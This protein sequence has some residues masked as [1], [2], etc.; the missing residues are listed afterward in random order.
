[1]RGVDFRQAIHYFEPEC[2]HIL[3][4]SCILREK[5]NTG[6]AELTVKSDNECIVFHNLD[7]HSSR[8]YKIKKCAD[9]VILENN[10]GE[11]ILHIFELKKTIKKNEWNTMKE[12]F[13]GALFNMMSYATI[14]GIS[15]DIKKTRVYSA[16][17]ED[18]LND[19]TNPSKKHYRKP[20]NDSQKIK[21]SMEIKQAR[22][23]W[24]SG[25]VILEYLGDYHVPN[26]KIKLRNENDIGV[27]EWDL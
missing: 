20:V 12:Q 13:Q 22:K 6:K 17:R 24:N 9:Q 23:E 27:G 5:T 18:K 16:Y 10:N 15:I 19:K 11:W 26:I 3:Q 2:V 1:M 7:K 14:L 25:E 8:L 4:K 21:D